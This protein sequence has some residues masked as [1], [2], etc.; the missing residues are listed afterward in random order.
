M[1][2]IKI[3]EIYLYTGQKWI[4]GTNPDG[5]FAWVI[6]RST[7]C[8]KAIQWLE[9]NGITDY[10]LMNYQDSELHE[11]CFAPLRTW[12][13]S[14]RQHDFGE[15][16]F[17]YYTEVHDDRPSRSMPIVLLFG[18]EEITNSNLPELYKLDKKTSGS[19]SKK[20]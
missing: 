7:D 16:P 5:S 18:L 14:G 2:I 17:L 15:F 1:S 9:D 6:D 13:F 20:K 8:G 19:R 11:D 4:E 10:T 12:N 3:E